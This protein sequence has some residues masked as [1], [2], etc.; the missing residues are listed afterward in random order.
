MEKPMAPLVDELLAEQVE[1]YRARA[2]EYDEAYERRGRHD[3]G[4]AANAM[5]LR[6]LGEVR[7]VLDS[8]PLDG[9]QVLEYAAGTGVWT[10]ALA[11]R[12]ATVTALDASSEMLE[13]NRARLGSL[14]VKVLYEQADVF[15]WRPQR[16]FDAAVFCF[17][18]THVPA[19]RLDSFLRNLAGALRPDGSVFFVDD[20]RRTLSFDVSAHTEGMSRVTVRRLNDGREYRVVKQFW[21]PAELEE[22]CR[23]AG[24]VTTICETTY[25][26]Y[27]VGRRR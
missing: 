2:A 22:R 25:F 4:A 24:L 6:E 10:E 16:S 12:G 23:L 17:W 11:A 15:S 1:Y 27:G 9:A 8:L 13:R 20:R 3:H 14:A 26:Q 21:E 7:A 18:L 5:W 19:E